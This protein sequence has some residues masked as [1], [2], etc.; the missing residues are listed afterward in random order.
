[1]PSGNYGLISLVFSKFS[2]LHSSLRD[3]SNFVKTLKVL[4]EL[5]LNCPRAHEITYTYQDIDLI[6]LRYHAHF[7]CHEAI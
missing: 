2:K 5:I 1:M 6:C 4:V 3:S 7:C